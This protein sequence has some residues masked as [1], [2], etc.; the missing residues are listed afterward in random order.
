MT[1]ITLDL[2]ALRSFV[3]GIELGGFARAADRLGRSTSAVSAQLK[4]LEGQAGAPILRKS[5]RGLAL[6]PTGE[7]LLA[8]ARRLI[9][10]NDEAVAAARGVELE[11]WVGSGC[12]RISARPCCR[13]P[14]AASPAPIP[15]SGSR[16]GSNATPR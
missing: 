10:L 2:D 6:T 1:R 5:G 3:V 4:K 9:E 14:W 12:R 11:G 15:R 16:R 7:T 8:Y 13:R